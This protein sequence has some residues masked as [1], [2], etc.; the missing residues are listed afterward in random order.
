MQRQFNPKLASL[1]RLTGK[2][3][4]PT[5]AVDQ[6]FGQSQSDSGA[7]LSAGFSAKTIKALTDLAMSLGGYATPGVGDGYASH[8]TFLFSDANRNAPA[9]AIVLD[10]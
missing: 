6:A 9:F 3:D 7:L 10:G 2:P 5:H 8:P 4:A 1:I